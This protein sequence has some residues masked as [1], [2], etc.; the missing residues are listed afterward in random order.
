MKIMRYKNRMKKKLIK[1]NNWLYLLLI[2]STK[3]EAKVL[4]QNIADINVKNVFK[5][6]II[7]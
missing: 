7:L 4:H 6:K 2:F 5:L 1:K 3:E